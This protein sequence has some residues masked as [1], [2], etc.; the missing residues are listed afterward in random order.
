M[1]SLKYI[2][3]IGANVNDAPFSSLEYLNSFQ[4]AATLDTEVFSLLLHY[5]PDINAP[6]PDY[7]ERGADINAAPASSH[8]IT[9]LQGAAI[10]GYMKVALILLEKGAD[11]NAAGAE[12]GGRTALEGAAEQGH[13]DM[14]Q[15]LLNAGARPS[16]SAAYLA[17]EE[18][19]FAIA[20]L[21]RDNLTSEEAEEVSQDL[22]ESVYGEDSD[23]F[24]SWES[25]QS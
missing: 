21:I 12:E 7:R 8:G 5:E 19:H 10:M 14:V 11:P 2:L 17:E 16:E 24:E 20:D 4:Y 15:L 1:E 3:Q 22:D 23:G 13:L 6:A 9:A 18:E 25:D